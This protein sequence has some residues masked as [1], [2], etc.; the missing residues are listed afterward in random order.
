MY[1]VFPRQS[2]LLSSYKYLIINEGV[3]EGDKVRICLDIS[4]LAT[5]CLPVLWLVADLRLQWQ[6]LYHITTI[7]SC[8]NLHVY[9]RYLTWCLSNIKHYQTQTGTT[10]MGLSF[11]QVQG[12]DSL[13]FVKWKGKTVLMFLSSTAEQHKMFIWAAVPLKLVHMK[14]LVHSPVFIIVILARYMLSLSQHGWLGST[15]VDRELH[16]WGSKW[17]HLHFSRLLISVISLRPGCYKRPEPLSFPA[18][19]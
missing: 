18:V 4:P 10:S 17:H 8:L 16:S 14:I 5:A 9:S 3:R 15:F 12:K 6:K 19:L 7:V 13:Y 1:L 11:Y 2:Y